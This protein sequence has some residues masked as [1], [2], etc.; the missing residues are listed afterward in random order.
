MKKIMLS[1]MSIPLVSAIQ[2]QQKPNV[3]VILADDLGYG[4]VSA[5]GSQTINTPNIDK[6]AKNGIQFNNGYATSA[7]STPSRYGLLTGMYP[8]KN[9]NARI[10]EGD[11][12]LLI[13]TARFTFPKM[14]KMAGY[15][16]AAIGKWHLGMGNGKID[17]NKTISPSVNDV[18]FD[19]SCVIAATVDRV[20]TVYI[21]NGKVADLDPGDPILVNYN[22]NFEGEPTAISNPEMLKM[23]WSHGHNNSIINGIPRIGFM[24]GGAKARWNDE[25]MA[26]YFAEKVDKYLEEQGTKP[27][28]LYY[29]L[30]EPHVPR[31]PH[32]DFVG[33][34]G[35]GPRGDA[36]LEADWCIGELLENL[37]KRNLLENTIIIFTSDNGPVLDDGYQDNAVE[38]LGNHQ[39]M[40]GLRGGKYS[41]FDAGTHVPFV[42][43]WKNGVHHHVSDAL[44]TQLDIMPSIAGLLKLDIPAG[45]DGENICKTL[46][47]KQDKGRKGFVIEASGRL[48][49]MSDN[50][51]MIPPYKGP[52][53][54][55]SGN[56]LGNLPDFELFNLKQDKAQTENMSAT[57]SKTLAKM[58]K[59]FLHITEG[60]YN[61]NVEQE[62]LK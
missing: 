44:M 41:L 58:K 54:N 42:F 23:N 10:L 50:W 24:K 16:T 62:K 61:P 1:L 4:D 38:M 14:M 32:N 51:V 60:F 21:E 28:F 49:Y 43:Y 5:Y 36:I 17:W 19:Y 39:P 59:A 57:K 55:E 37:E 29:G 25:N 20:P 9:A 30:H 56:E 26:Y 52:V 40:G 53:S 22:Q 33:K 8:W 15:N 48:A 18:G 34:S 35:M 31:T 13:D 2:A 27:F 47:G 11:A 7:T 45:L 6:L 46:S 3:I 12:P